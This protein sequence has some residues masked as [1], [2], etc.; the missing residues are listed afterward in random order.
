MKLTPNK[1][2]KTP[3]IIRPWIQDFTAAWVKGYI[4]YGD[5]EVAAQIK[6]MKDNGVDEYLL[7]NATNRYSEGGLGK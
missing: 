4:K 6:A 7:W 3:A 5:K 1:N 2:I